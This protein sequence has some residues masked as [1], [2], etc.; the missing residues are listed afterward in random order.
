FKAYDF[1]YFILTYK[2]HIGSRIFVSNQ[3]PYYHG[4]KGTVYVLPNQQNIA[5]YQAVVVTLAVVA[6]R[7]GIISLTTT[8][9]QSENL[10]DH[11]SC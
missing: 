5:L 11:H 7:Q 3:N 9:L 8:A 4:L 6:K 10:Q 2:S 1:F